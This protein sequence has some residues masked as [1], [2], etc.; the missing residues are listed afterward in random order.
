MILIISTIGICS[1]S[2]LAEINRYALVI[3]NSNYQASNLKLR[4]PRA[5]AE[6]IYR[7]LKKIGFQTTI[8]NDLSLNGMKEII[9][10]FIERSQGA[11]VVLIYYAG[12]GIQ[13][14]GK[15]YLVPTDTSSKEIKLSSLLSVQSTLNKTHFNTSQF[16]MILDACRN[17]PMSKASITDHQGKRLMVS[18]GLSIS[19]MSNDDI[20]RNRKTRRQKS[21]MIVFSTSPG[22]V[23]SD[24]SGTNSPFAISFAKHLST[25]SVDLSLVMRNVVKDV[26]M[27]TQRRQSPWVNASLSEP[28]FLYPLHLLDCIEVGGKKYCK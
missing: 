19:G 9:S 26:E 20:S 18:R 2:A 21:T 12:H 11:E 13:V 8:K 10:T 3:G 28:I 22:D 15:N 16:V 27:M 7:E 6:L 4:N 1:T 25:P 24:G 23:A 5:D 17:N 14:G